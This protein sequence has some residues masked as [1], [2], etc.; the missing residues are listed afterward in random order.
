MN[1]N[2]Q[3]FA[4]ILILILALFLHME[5]FTPDIFASSIG[6][7]ALREEIGGIEFKL[8]IEGKG[9][10]S[11]EELIIKTSFANI[12]KEPISY[13]AGSTSEGHGRVVGAALKSLDE[14]SY[15]TDKLTAQMAGQAAN[16]Q[17]S[18]G[19]LMPGEAINVD[20]AML[21]FYKKNGEVKLAK[22]GQ[23][24]LSLWYSKDANNVVKAEFPITVSKRFGKMYIK[25]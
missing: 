6:P 8:M 18:T 25:S 9:F 3:Q 14:S 24:I 5:G 12:G 16:A 17:V 22:S 1:N 21:P 19:Q 23:Y 13:Y 10:T 2:R 7:V 20:F 15:F 11:T 4:L